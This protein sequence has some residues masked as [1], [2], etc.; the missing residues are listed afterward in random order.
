MASLSSS[1]AIA[2]DTIVGVELLNDACGILDDLR[3]TVWHLL[4]EG[5]NDGAD[6]HLLELLPALL[7]HTEV[8]DGEQSDSSWRL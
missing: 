1:T 5:V 2:S 4:C 3:V 8:T 6:A 7:V